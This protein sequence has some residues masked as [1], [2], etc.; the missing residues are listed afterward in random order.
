[1]SGESVQL[2][3][4]FKVHLIVLA[5]FFSA[6]FLQRAMGLHTGTSV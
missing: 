6:R 5:G 4:P 3:D 2:T 1:M